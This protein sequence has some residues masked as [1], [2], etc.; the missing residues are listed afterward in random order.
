MD[1]NAG[2]FGEPLSHDRMLMSSVVVDDQVQ[3]QIRRRF[4][5]YAFEEREPFEMRV[6]W[7]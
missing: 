4:A 1:V 2:M 3:S 5:V 6:P 7:Y